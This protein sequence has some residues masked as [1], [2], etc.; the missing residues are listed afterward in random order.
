M[1]V[2]YCVYSYVVL[3]VGYMCVVCCGVR[4]VRLVLSSFLFMALLAFFFFF[5][6]FFSFGL[7]LGM[8][9]TWIGIGMNKHGV[10]KGWY[11]IWMPGCLERLNLIPSHYDEQ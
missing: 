5:F 4:C 3:Y 9:L 1:Y 8:D 10:T 2:V 11:A 6:I 7:S